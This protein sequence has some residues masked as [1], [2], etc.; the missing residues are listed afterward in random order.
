MISESNLQRTFLAVSSLGRW[1]YL[2]HVSCFLIFSDIILVLGRGVSI[3]EVNLDWLK[4][5]AS[6]G[7][8]LVVVVG[9]SFTKSFLLPVFDFLYFASCVLPVIGIKL[10]ALSQREIGLPTWLSYSLLTR[11]TPAYREFERIRA[12]N[13]ALEEGSNNCRHLALLL[14]VD[15]LAGLSTGKSF[16]SGLYA[17]ID[18][19][20]DGRR[21]LFLVPLILFLLVLAYNALLAPLNIRVSISV[22][23][24][25]LIREISRTS[26]LHEGITKRSPEDG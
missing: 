7:T 9:Y 24:E 11:S 19:L 1:E 16:A 15:L 13:R 2:L 4:V 17:F 26:E 22:K 10:R 23:N 20:Q 6:L 18:S 8:A 25:A 3:S 21:Y 12:K 5:N 14:L